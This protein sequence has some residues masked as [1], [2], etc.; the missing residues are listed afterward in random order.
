[1]KISIKIIF[2]THRSRLAGSVFYPGWQNK[3]S[4]DPLREAQRTQ[5]MVGL[6]SKA[7]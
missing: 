1:M 5:V 4:I 2:K 3:G 7:T 6:V